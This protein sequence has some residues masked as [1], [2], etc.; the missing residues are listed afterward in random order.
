MRAAIL[1][2]IVLSVGGLMVRSRLASGDAGL[3]PD[4]GVTFAQHPQC[5]SN[6]SRASPVDDRTRLEEVVPIVGTIFLHLI[7][8]LMGL[9]PGIGSASDVNG[10][11]AWALIAFCVYTY[12]GIQKHGWRYIHQFMGPAFDLTIGGKHYHVR[13]L[14]LFMMLIEIPLNLAHRHADDSSSHNMFA[15][16][17]V[18]SVWLGSFRSRSRP[19]FLAS[20]FGLCDQAFVFSLLTM[21]YIGL[22]L[23]AT[24]GSATPAIPLSRRSNST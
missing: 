2:G 17:T 21:I 12:A 11:L 16:H 13:V 8:N 22:A 24:E 10:G 4:S 15:D 6:G 5:S 14:A 1:A 19:S 9:L 7:S 18:L 23:E 20:G 3:V